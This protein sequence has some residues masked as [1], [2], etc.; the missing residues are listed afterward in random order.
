MKFTPSETEK[1]FAERLAHFGLNQE[2][3]AQKAGLSD[4]DISRYKAQKAHPRLHI[5]EPLAAAFEVDVLTLLIVLGAIDPD[6]GGTPR[7]V[8]GQKNSKVVWKL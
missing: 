3:F 6:G 5:I 1:W 8:K 7:L 2:Q 4:S